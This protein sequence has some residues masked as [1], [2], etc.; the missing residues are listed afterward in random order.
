MS[1][2]NPAVNNVMRILNNL[3]YEPVLDSD[4]TIKV[5]FNNNLKYSI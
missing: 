3:S 5:T 1:S 2:E 4:S